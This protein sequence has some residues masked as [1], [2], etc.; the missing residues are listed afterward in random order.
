MPT[1]TP[2]DEVETLSLHRTVSYLLEECRIVLP[3]IQVLFGFQLA[4]VFTN[5]FA[6][7]LGAGEQRLYLLSIGLIALAI[8]LIMTPAAYH[9]QAEP[10]QVSQGF[11]RVSTVL[12]LASM[13]PLAIAICLD[14]YL[15]ARLVLG[16]G[17]VSWLAGGLFAVFVG[18]WFVLPRIARWRRKRGE[19]A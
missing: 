4:T 5:R 17:P 18:L 13:P 12:L 16:A 6:T 11:V 14:F 10:Q 2:P 3:G 7:A 15:V 1:R 8:A 19:R 9:R